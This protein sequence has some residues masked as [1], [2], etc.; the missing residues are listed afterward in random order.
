MLEYTQ[1]KGKLGRY[2]L[3]VFGPGHIVMISELPTPRLLRRGP[4][5]ANRSFL[6]ISSS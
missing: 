3:A 2:K 5:A 4:L 1:N 6:D